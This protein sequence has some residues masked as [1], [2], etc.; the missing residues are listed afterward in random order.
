[1]DGFINLLKPAGMTSHDAVSR[2]RRITGIKRIGH[3]GTLDPMA[4]GVLPMSIGAATR[5]MEYLDQDHKSYRCEVQLGITTDTLDIWGAVTEQTPV[6]P[7]ALS[8]RRIQT[9][10]SN[11]LGE[12]RQIPPTYSAI[13]V[14]GRKLYEYARE[15]RDVLIKERVVTFHALDLIRIDQVKKRFLL[16][17][18]CSKGTYLRSL[19]RDLG[20]DLGCAASMSFLLRTASGRFR[21]EETTTLEEVTDHFEDKL[22][23]VEYPLQ[24][25]GRVQVSENQG[26]WF[27]NGGRLDA[28]RVKILEEP[29]PGHDY[30][31][32]YQDTK[33]LGMAALIEGSLKA[34]KVFI[35]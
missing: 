28:A 5:M 17:V 4:T 31:G 13:K 20:V 18:T 6:P 7:E 34:H 19:C 24:G 32:I 2:L 9:I 30:Y 27:A 35:R 16:D 15:G 23:P 26:T 29:E 8:E 14:D 1:M 10:L 21:L 25:Y 33:F 22:L 3:T 11:Y 12:H